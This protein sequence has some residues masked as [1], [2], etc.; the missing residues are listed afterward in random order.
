[1]SHTEGEAMVTMGAIQRSLQEDASVD[2]QGYWITL[3]ES[4]G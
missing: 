4:P 3:L 1:M 2:D